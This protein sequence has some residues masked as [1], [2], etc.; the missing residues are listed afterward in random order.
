MLDKVVVADEVLVEPCE[1]MLSTIKGPEVKVAEGESL[2]FELLRVEGDLL[3]S[4][5]LIHHG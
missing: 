3:G 1:G 2:S 5:L 4:H